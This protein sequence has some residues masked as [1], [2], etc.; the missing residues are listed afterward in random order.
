MIQHDRTPDAGSDDTV[1]PAGPP[2]TE[3]QARAEAPEGVQPPEAEPADP[4]V[5]GPEGP[6]VS[7]PNGPRAADGPV[8]AR[9]RLRTR[10]VGVAAGVALA[11]AVGTGAWSL[12]TAARQTVAATATVQEPV[13]ADAPDAAGWEPPSR[14]VPPGAKSLDGTAPGTSVLEQASAT[15]ATSAQQVGLVTIVTTLGYQQS[16]AA[17]TGIVLTSDGTVLT[18]NH[19]V[20]GATEIEVTVESTGETFSAEVVGTDATRDVAVLQLDA[21]S[22]LA[23]ATIDA[24][25]DDGALALGDPVTAVG[26]A[27]GAGTLMA[28]AG[29]V[30]AL[31]ETITTQDSGATQGTTLVGLVEIQAD[32]VAGDSGGAVLDAD[33]DVVGMTTA[34]SSG[35][36]VTSG[37][38]IAIGDALDVAAGILAGED[39]D[40]VTIGY[41]AFLGVVLGDATGDTAGTTSGAVISGVLDGT[42]AAG[43]GLAAGDV[44]TSV[45]GVAVGTADALAQDLAQREPGES[46]EIGW[47]SAD[48]AA[49]V[50]TVVL[51]EGPAD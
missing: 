38:A 32:V 47:T 29:T 37:Y 36:G 21:A 6:E 27:E 10:R 19:V 48:G 5:A 9:R 11:L 44:V 2:P 3:L 15:T 50:A 20:E 23:T 22:G 42:P 39:T 13:T 1:A 17:G 41:P 7:G 18:N 34:A 46:V 40:T 35:P 33:G 4:P 8:A 24:G 16:E 31:D 14:S 49:H 45:D 43:A 26:N 51:T 30:T 28:A 12:S 25:D